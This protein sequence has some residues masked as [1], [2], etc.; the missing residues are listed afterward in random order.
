MSQTPLAQPGLDAISAALELS[1]AHLDLLIQELAPTDP[2]P[3]PKGGQVPIPGWRR[4]CVV[5]LYLRPTRPS[6]RKVAAQGGVSKSSVSRLL[7]EIIPHIVTK[8]L[9]Q[10]DGTFL[11]PAD[12]QSWLC[13]MSENRELAL[14]DGTF[15][16]VTR[17]Q[18]G[19]L[20]RLFYQVKSGTYCYQ[21]LVLSTTCGDVLSLDG[22]WPGSFSELDILDHSAFLSDLET[23]E[24][25]VLADRGFR[26]V[27]KRTEGKWALPVG[28][29]SKRKELSEETQT[30]NWCQNSVRAPA[31]HANAALKHWGM[32]RFSRFSIVRFREMERAVATVLMLLRYGERIRP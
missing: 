22:G 30:Y 3:C 26:G 4:L 21:S 1:R 6:M 13:E 9:L 24:V 7:Q 18:T 25:T 19:A 29:W 28:Y 14:L 8:G 5:L 31:E 27:E 23:S 10:A 11:Q 2:P 17:P 16:Q 15:T 32:M 20:R 12:L